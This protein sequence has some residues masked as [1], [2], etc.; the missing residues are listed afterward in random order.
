MRPSP[1]TSG[2]P[3]LTVA[4]AAVLGR[5]QR[6]G[7]TPVATTRSKAF[8]RLLAVALLG[9]LAAPA[10][11]QQQQQG[12]CTRVK[13]EIL[14]ELTLERVGFEATLEVTNNDGEDPITDFSAQLTFE[15]PSLSS[16]GVVNDASTMFFVRAPELEGIN[17]V[18]GGGIIPP[19][20]KIV[21]RWF[22]IPKPRAGGTQ[23][24]GVRYRVGCNLSGKIRGEIIPSDVLNAI[25]DMIYVRPEPLLDIL[26][27]QPRDVQGDDP[28]TAAVE[29]PI[30]FTLGVLVRNVGYGTARGVKIRSEQPRIVENKQNLLLIAQLLGVRVMDA[31]LDRTSLTVDIGDVD[32]SRTR[33]AAWDMITSLSG[34][35][36]EFKASY[37]HA[38]ELGGEETSIISNITAHFI[39]H[40]V[41]NDQAGRDAILD[42]L[43]D[44]DRDA[45]MIPDA[46]YES[47]GNILPVNR[48]TDAALQGAAG[49][50][51][52]TVKATATVGSWAYVRIDDPGQAKLPLESVVRSDGKR[53]DPHNF[54]T[55]V[56]YSKNN[57]QR[58]AYFNLFDLVNPG[59]NTYTV[60][61]SREAQDRKPPVTTIE[62]AGP[63]SAA[64]SNTYYIARDT[65]IY[66]LSSDDSP[67]SIYYSLTNSPFLPA[68]PFRLS[69]PGTYGVGFYAADA[70]GNTETV[71]RATLVLGG[72]RPELTT[73]DVGADP[74]VPSGDA[75][76]FRAKDAH[77][78]FQV[79]AGA[80]RVDAGVDV[81]RGVMAW[82]SLSSVPSSPTVLPFASLAVGGDFVDFYR[83]RL[84]NGAW[85]AERA[86]S[87]RIVVTGLATGTHRVDVLARSSRGDYPPD[88]AAVSAS[89]VVDRALTL[90]TYV[91]N[92]PPTPTRLTGAQLYVGGT[93]VT[94]YR[95]T[96]NAGYYRV[97]APVATPISLGPLGA[98]V[99]TVSV[100]GKVGAYPSTN[101]ATSVSWLVDPM[102]GY[103]C[104]ALARVRSVTFSNCAGRVVDFAWDGRN[105]RGAPA[106]PGWYTVRLTL[107][108][109]LGQTNFATRLVEVG[110]L[111]P[112]T[113]VVA[114]A[115]RGADR[116]F[117]RG[118]YT[119]WEDQSDGNFE[120]YAW[121]RSAAT[122]VVSKVTLGTR[123]Q[124]RPCTDGRYATW[125]GRRTDGTWDV[126]VKEIGK[127]VLP[128]LLTYTPGVDE[129]N[130]TIDWPWVAYQSRAT[131][132]APWQL[133]V[134]NLVT[135]VLS[136]VSPSPADQ[137]D[138]Y[139]CGNRL[140]WQD[141]RDVGPGEI[142]CKDLESGEV[143]RITDNP[144]GQYHPAVSDRWLVWQDNRNGQ[145]DLYAWDF[146]RK[147]EVRLTSTPENE[148][149]PGID[150]Q[151]VVCLEDSLGPGLTNLR[152]IHMPSRIV[153]PLTRTE[154]VKN[155]PS[156]AANRA[157]W[158]ETRGGSNQVISASLPALH[159]VFA[160]VNAV[161][162]TRQIAT[163]L[164][165]AFTLLTRWHEEAGVTAV[166]RYVALV[167]AV[168]R[169]TATWSNGAPTGENFPLVAGTFVWVTFSGARV[170]DLGLDETPGLDLPA[171]VS[172]VSFTQ[173]PRPFSAYR[174]IRQVG[175][176][177]VR[178][179]R[180]MDSASGRW[181]V[182]EVVKGAIAG[183]DFNIPRS[184]VLLIDMKK[185]VNGWTPE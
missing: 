106:V 56:R 151:W 87:A 155:Y 15:N 20:Q 52:F 50:G 167:P 174:L 148:A 55:N 5:L 45:E 178:S 123:N 77:I 4:A 117:S 26:Y 115:T 72:D 139:L 51:G 182:A 90:P 159:A 14:Q 161:P 13:I 146:Q 103:D 104:S 154:T 119:V 22:I 141:W 172:S 27:F 122:S 59:A 80:T 11:A 33:K 32:P 83:Y 129:A 85:S 9:L 157:V 150:G 31:P 34:E 114:A 160:D 107:V 95:W 162:V 10:P 82:P 131:P 81:F 71:H 68:Y 63:M 176:D 93:N 158:L 64:A 165:D 57:N 86:A 145:L 134:R 126:Y 118:R 179:V 75:L 183:Y 140:V 177:N 46:L 28:F 180:M 29:A 105:D 100:I 125:Q 135:G 120:I 65:Q 61:Y 101:R 66:F 41:L 143:T 49:P 133:L 92:T 170:L 53:L 48:L 73:L 58:L 130:P 97:E 164:V 62:F 166:S 171:G 74:L 44:T 12:I 19:T 149:M 67:V 99:Q 132:T 25:P 43:A 173:F 47:E 112:P 102:Y 175:L 76:S 21:S 156:L 2:Y 163:N 147:S 108:N 42:F 24:G 184:A 169:Q 78:K 185:A 152:L 153:I 113:S 128:T 88:S 70:S 89:W 3:A 98:G 181:L 38:P 23:P 1:E 136:P 138:P 8:G 124:Q 7:R 69:Q 137:L 36:V 142:Y 60:T 39:A 37:T 127:S 91:T 17:D 16:N 110:Q 30:P 116:P 144:M 94:H 18:D 111:Y 40:E 121:K 79:P 109:S 84:D 6:A 96:I 35:F 168:R 54:W